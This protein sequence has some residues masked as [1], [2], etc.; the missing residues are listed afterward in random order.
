MAEDPAAVVRRFAGSLPGAYED[1]PW[2][3]LVVKV[4]KK[5]FVFLGSPPDMALSVGV[6]LRD[7]HEAALSLGFTSPM[8]YG[9]GRHGWV[10]ASFAAG[11]EPPV[12]LLCDWIDESYR[13]VAGKRR[14]AELDGRAA[15]R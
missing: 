10:T 8:G 15:E 1:F 13:L 6:K 7:S 11:D 12:E 14:V 4:G 2:D 5:V 9:L 3:E